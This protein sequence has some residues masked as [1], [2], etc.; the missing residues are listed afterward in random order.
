MWSSTFNRNIIESRASR[1]T[2]LFRY[3]SPRGCEPPREI[4]EDFYDVDRGGYIALHIN[5]IKMY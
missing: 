1:K 3:A 4:D 5:R 2:Q